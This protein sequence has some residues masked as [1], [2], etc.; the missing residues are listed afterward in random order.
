M[1]G[2]DPGA[3]A[4]AIIDQNT[5]MTLATVDDQGLPWAS[6]VFFATGDYHDFFWV[7]APTATHSRNIARRG[8]VGV[9]IFDSTAPAGTGQAVYMS[10]R[11]EQVA[12]ADIDP[13]LAVYPGPQERGGHPIDAAE[14]RDSA[15]YRL[16]R[17]TAREYSILCPRDSDLCEP[18]GLG[19]DHRLPVTALVLPAAGSHASRHTPSAFTTGL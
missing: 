13:A 18:H 3:I 10:A 5:Y 16:Y 7:S 9:V 11:A 17:A 14:V 1:S 6:P 4:R 2:T 12:E 8:E 15:P 19:Y